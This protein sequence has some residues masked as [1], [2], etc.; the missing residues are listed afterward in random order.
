[1]SPRLTIKTARGTLDINRSRS[2]WARFVPYIRRH[3]RAMALASLAAIGATLMTLA[4][5]WTI[6]VIFDYVLSDKMRG[7][8]LA[9]LIDSFADSPQQVLWLV[10]LF[11]LVIAVLDGVFN[12]TRDVL[13]AQTGQK[14]VGRLRQKLFDHLQQLTPTELEHRR[15]GDL[16]A[17]LTGDIIMLR[18]MLTGTVVLL[19]ESVLMMGVMLAAMFYIN[20]VIGLVVV[21]L[22]PITLTFAWLVSRRIRSIARSQREK[23]GEVSNIA[24][25]V[26][27]AM[28]TIQAYNREAVEAERF[29]RYNRSTIRAGV[30]TTKLESRLYR[31]VSFNSAV[32]LSVILLVGVRAVLASQITAGDLLVIVAYWRGF[33]KPMRRVS[34]VA[35]QIAKS[36][37]CGERVGE[38]LDLKPSITDRHTATDLN[39]IDGRIRFEDV[40][41]AY[42]AQT[43]PV[44][45]GVD[46]EVTQGERI[47]VVGSSGAGKSTLIK[48]LL[49]FY[50]PDQ[51]AVR[52]DGV[53]IRDITRSSL[54]HH[55]GWVQQETVLFGLTIAENIALGRVEAS[56][57]MVA[58]AARR[59]QAHGFIESLPDGYDTVLGQSGLTLSGGERQR[60]ALARAL[61]REPHILLLDEPATGLDARTRQVVTQCWMSD[62]NRATTIVICHRLRDMA[63]FDRI[64][65]LDAGAVLAF[66]NHEALI[67]SCPEYANAHATE[68]GGSAESSYTQEAG[69]C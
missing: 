12:Y 39:Q 66:D 22:M 27:S 43:P 42:K 54:R 69:V 34:K 52:I 26:L 1:M 65:V 31:L 20:P 49:R 60:I 48:L 21:M 3:W 25:D 9:N 15:T 57:E 44:L 8:P 35:S 7:T 55:I 13:L 37:A 51:G 17:R 14:I 62:Q 64:L 30:K 46:F 2:V 10:I 53:D 59:V 67:R 19:L 61:L 16:L 6:K 4:M 24:H 33:S 45:R 36:T 11:L 38:L 63:R 29:G 68:Q 18:Q 5:P 23:E 47:A 32:T 50:D 40:T 58:D 28:P 56:R 41:F